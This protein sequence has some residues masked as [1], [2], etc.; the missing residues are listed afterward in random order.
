PQEVLRLLEV[1]DGARSR[2]MALLL[3]LL[4]ETGLR[5]GEALA[6]QWRDVDLERGELRVWRSWTKVN[7]KGDFTQPKTRTARRVVP[8]PHSLLLRLPQ[9]VLEEAFLFGGNKPFDPDAFNHYLRRLAQRAGLGKV[10]VHDLRH[11]WASLALSR[12]IPLEVVSERLGHASPHVTLGIYR[13]LLEEERRGYVVD[14]KT[15]LGLPAV[16]PQA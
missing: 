10:R 14:L 4:L 9:E 11:T 13:H 16:R 2:E 8:L 3:R 1:A 5:R 6:L 7:G 15:L 12:G